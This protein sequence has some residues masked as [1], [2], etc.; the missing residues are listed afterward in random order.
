MIISTIFVIWLVYMLHTCKQDLV[1]N[2]WWKVKCHQTSGALRLGW[3]P[4]S[5]NIFQFFSLGGKSDVT[6][7]GALGLRWELT[8]LNIFQFFSL[9][10]KSD[11][12]KPLGP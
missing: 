9:S 10:G 12:T 2:S 6:K 1:F 4:T 5:L 7:P 3:E 8:S 11:V